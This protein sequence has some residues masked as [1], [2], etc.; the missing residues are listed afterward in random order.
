MNTK[1]NFPENFIWGAATASYQIE[2]AVNED[3]RGKT[4]WDTFSHTPGKTRNGD[5]GDVACDH[6]HR[7]PEDIRLMQDLGISAYR[8]S[9]AWARI[10][11]QGRGAVNQ[12]GL[13]FYDRLID[14]VLEANIQPCPTLY[15]WDLPQALQDE[16]GWENRQTIE[17]FKQY[18]DVVTTHFGDRLKM[19]MTFNEPFVAALVGNFQGRHAPGNQDLGIALSVAHHLLVAHGRAVPIIRQNVS[20][21]Q[22]GI[23]LNLS[24]VMAEDPNNPEHIQAEQNQDGHVNR[25][26][27][28]PIY[29]GT[30]PKDMWALYGDHVPTIEDGDME[31]IATET[32]F[33][34]INYYTRAVVRSTDAPPLNVER[35]NPPGIKTEMGWSI[36]PQGLSDLLKRVHQEYNPKAIYITENGAAF[37]DTVETDGSVND[38]IRRDYIHKHLIECH[39]SIEAGV[40]LKG[41]FVWSML[42]NFEWGLGY[43]KR[44]GI[45][46]INYE[47]LE[48][49]MKLSG[50]WYAGVVRENGL[51]PIKA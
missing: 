1:I 35:I 31:T 40:P 19:W 47:T 24:H 20:D 37:N 9:F 45:I 43:T 4:I 3:G 39:Q 21:A 7:Y 22:V 6:Y 2:G 15:H 41:Y 10:L 14:A 28:D 17:A 18:T 23:V 27:L 49:T 8:F 12:A 51:T 13:D 32:D 5:T 38:E 16:G 34:G 48:R 11:P 42:D 36:Y 25:W 30:Y 50:K 26:F 29:H 44:F 33:L 46:R